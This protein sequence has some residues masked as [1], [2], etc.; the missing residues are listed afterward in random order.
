MGFL[1]DRRRDLLS[2]LIA[3]RQLVRLIIHKVSSIIAN[4][5]IN[6]DNAT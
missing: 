1:T 3:F 2:R 6:R 5:R 4:I